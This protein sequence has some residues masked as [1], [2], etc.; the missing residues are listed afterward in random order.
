MASG[1]SG[2]SS[3]ERAGVQQERMPAA[4]ADLGGGLVL[5]RG[6]PEDADALAAFSAL[7]HG[8]AERPDE[9][10]AWWT[11]DLLSGMHPT[12]PPEDFTVVEETASG[13]IVSSLCLISQRWIYGGVELGVGRPE[14]V[15]TLPEYRRRGLI[16][17]QMDVVHRWSAERGELMQAITGIPWYYRQFGYEMALQQQGIRTGFRQN[18]P[19][20]AAGQ[21][22][23]FRFR[24]AEEADLPFLMELEARSRRRSLVAAVRDG[25]LW[26]YELR[27]RSAGNTMRREFWIIERPGPEPRTGGT[28]ATRQPLGYLAL[29]PYTSTRIFLAAYELVPPDGQERGDSA[30][31]AGGA[32]SWLDVT[33][34]VLRFLDA[35]GAAWEP[36]GEGRRFDG[37]N[38]GLHPEHP[39]FRAMPGLFPGHERPGA[40]YVRVPDLPRFLRHVAPVL[41]AR[42]AASPLAGYSGDFRL[43]FYRDGVRLTFLGGRLAGAEPWQRPE[44]RESDALFPDLTFLSLLFG[45]LTFE[46][47]RTVFPDCFTRSDT[48]RVLVETLFPKLG[49]HVWLVG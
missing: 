38:V 24:P 37:Y 15:A 18:V 47:L 36:A 21:D 40:T 46:E 32:A 23:P 30:A 39:V 22:E 10:V 8:S 20:L 31:P 6:R 29:W 17:R 43:S 13:R 12:F 4:L 14:L 28:S 9:G 5:R 27:G 44:R 1:G 3:G 2:G 34:S 45:R 41:E 33:P 42:L 19:V 35:K 26:R 48:A 11:R 49:S 16:R 7:M 25:A